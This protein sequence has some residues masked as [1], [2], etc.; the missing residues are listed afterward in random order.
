MPARRFPPPWSVEEQDACFVVVDR[1]GPKA[2]VHL[3]RGRAGP[4]IGGQVAHEGRGAE[5]CGQHGEVAAV[6][7][8]LLKR[9]PRVNEA[10]RIAVN[11]AKLVSRCFCLFKDNRSSLI[12][13]KDRFEYIAGSDGR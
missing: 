11:I 12:I 2:R 8:R 3:F 5:D 1:S 13:I 9:W 6:V 10:R 7:A 4:A